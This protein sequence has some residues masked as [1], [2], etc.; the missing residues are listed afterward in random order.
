MRPL[1]SLYMT[2]PDGK[3]N[4]MAAE[5]LFFICTKAIAAN[6][7]YPAV[8]AHVREMLSMLPVTA[9]ERFTEMPFLFEMIVESLL[10]AL[11][12]A[13]DTA[14]RPRSDLNEAF[15]IHQRAEIAGALPVCWP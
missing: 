14:H 12:L 15:V 13:K 10:S 7:D 6:D 5:R 3:V 2:I 11:Q 8:V 9:I 4:L 1:E